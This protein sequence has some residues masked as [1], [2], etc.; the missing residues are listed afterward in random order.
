MLWLNAK[1][2]LMFGSYFIGN[3]KIISY[4]LKDNKGHYR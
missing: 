3:N 4:P 1:L 2:H